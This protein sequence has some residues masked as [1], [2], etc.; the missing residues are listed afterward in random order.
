M[1]STKRCASPSI[2][3]GQPGHVPSNLADGS[4]CAPTDEELTTRARNGDIEAFDELMDR[5]RSMCMRRAWWKLRNRS[6]AEDVVQSACRKA[7]QRLDQYQ[8]TGRFAAWIGRI[9]ENE[10]LMRFREQKSTRF[11][12]MDNPA[13][14]DLRL[15]LVSQNQNPEDEFGRQEVVKLLE[16]EVS[17]MPPIFRNII[18]LHDSDQLPLRDVA[19]RLGL[20]LPAAKSRL[21]R[22]RQEL[23]VRIGKHCGRKGPGTLLENAVCSRT[24]YA[25][26]S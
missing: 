15:E 24:A 17:R 12:Y 3:P 2:T 20:S 26:A 7:F 13:E 11:V 9:V 22:A 1:L 5:H 6:D 21:R 4:S 14:S 10:C 18:L 25:Q 8:G 16:K 19:E 23:C